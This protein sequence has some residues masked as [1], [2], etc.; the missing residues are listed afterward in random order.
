VYV[1][2]LPTVSV[3]SLPGVSI[4]NTPTVNIGNAPSVT[5]SPGASVRDADNP[6]LQAWHTNLCVNA[7]GSTS[8]GGTNA[9]QVPSGR[10][11][12][13]EFVSG[14]CSLSGATRVALAL[15]T[16]IEGQP[17]THTLH[18]IEGVGFL[19]VAQTMRVYAEA[20]SNVFLV[21]GGLL[22]Q[23]GACFM[24]LSGHTVPL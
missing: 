13:I 20:D 12:V 22:G 21:I 6:A 8:C 18:L 14:T 1:A 24:A 4:A 3:G 7:V 15:V 19:D 11:L 2:S 5:L 23:G 10:R 9:Y 16:A 17:A